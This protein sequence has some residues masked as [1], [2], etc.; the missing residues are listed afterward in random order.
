MVNYQEAWVRPTN[1]RLKK[2]KSAAKNKTRKILRLTKKNIEDGELPHEFFRRTRQ[3]I[4][5][6]NVVA[7]NMSTD[8]KLSKD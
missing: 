7:N 6:C 5:I 8:T 1:K 4:K 2:F 3:K